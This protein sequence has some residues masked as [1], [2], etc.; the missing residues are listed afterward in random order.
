VGAAALPA[1]AGQVRRDRVDQ[2]GV[3]VGGD[4]QDTGQAAGDQVGEERVPCLSGLAGGDFDA[5]DFAVAVGVDAGRDEHDRFDHAALLTD[6][7]GQRVGGHEGE[8]PGLVQGPGPECRDLGVEIGGHA[9]DLRAGQR[10]DAQRLDEFVH[11]PGRDAEQV[12]GRDHAD[13]G[14]LG[15]LTPLEQPVREIRALP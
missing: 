14:G 2:A 7:H 3:R 4:Q 8:R 9:G 10:G 12:A 13:H 5:E 6:L 1:G 15:P 11:P